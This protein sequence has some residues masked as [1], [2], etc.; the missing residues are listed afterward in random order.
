MASEHI[1]GPITRKRL[2]WLAHTWGVVVFLLFVA[3]AYSIGPP[4][5]PDGPGRE[6]I[7]QELML[8][9]GGIAVL[10]SWR[11]EGI[12]GWLLTFA[13]IVLG[14]AAAV[15]F[16]PLEAL[17]VT[18]LFLVPG[19]SLLFLWSTQHHWAVMA[20]TA[21]AVVIGMAA[22]GASAV[23]LHAHYFGPAHPQSEI[24][25]RPA[26]Q[27]TWAW[28][29]ALTPT[30]IRVNAQVAPGGSTARLAVST[31]SALDAPRWS[32]VKAV[33]TEANRVVAFAMTELVPGTDYFYAV[34][35][36]G[37][38]DRMRSGEF[39][40]PPDSPFSFTIALGSCARVGSNGSVYD[41][42]RE[43]D[44]LM[45]LALGDMH[46]GNIETNDLGAFY[47]VLDTTLT[48]PA[49]LSLYLSTPIAYLWDDHDFGGNN[50]NASSASAPA[51]QR[52]YREYVPHYDLQDGEGAIYQA[53]TIGRVRFLVTDTRS[54][55]EGDTMLGARQ[56]DWLKAEMLAARDTHALTVWA[57]SVPWIAGE[58]GVADHWGRY[59]EER[60]DIADFIAQHDLADSM[61]MVAGDAHMLAIDDGTNSD[62]ST[63]RNASFPVLHAAALDRP[64]TVKGGPYSEGT[65]P[66]GGQFATMAVEDDG[67][68]TI[69]VS[70][71]GYNWDLEEIVGLEME[72]E[73]AAARTAVAG[74]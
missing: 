31:D 52:S 59:P 21:S 54:A 17:L 45:F 40:T 16:P 64:G 22:G 63:S 56:I 65:F 47:D 14:V 36:D 33:S 42:I 23:S 9:G 53:F 60:A 46:Y 19:L 25:A 67:G 34:E 15:G 7:V 1:A 28:S 35:V 27:I 3:F 6:Q 43:L 24:A 5:S 73:V 26:S 8:I 70:W 72:F 62:Y 2:R 41:T 74:P 39:T 13:G 29:G 71:Q 38:L 37:E 68:D 58:S 11:W 50:S 4:V 51:A 55:R 61:V 18:L 20:G 49:Q 48:S 12:G 30:A 66:G 69:R 57:S 10:L 32:E 44:P